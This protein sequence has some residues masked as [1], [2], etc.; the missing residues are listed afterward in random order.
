[1]GRLVRKNL[2]RKEK[3]RKCLMEMLFCWRMSDSA[4]KICR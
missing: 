2:S 1:M 3:S 4:S